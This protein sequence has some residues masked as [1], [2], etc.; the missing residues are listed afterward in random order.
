[1]LQFGYL[2]HEILERAIMGLPDE[3]VTQGEPKATASA[4]GRRRSRTAKHASPT[5]TPPGP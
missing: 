5:S 4:E 2:A 3:P 1:M